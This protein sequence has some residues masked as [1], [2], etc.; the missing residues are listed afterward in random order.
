MAMFGL[1]LESGRCPDG[2]EIV[3]TAE[4]EALYFHS[5]TVRREQVRLEIET[6]E[7]PVVVEFINARTD[8]KLAEFFLNYGPLYWPETHH[9]IS[10]PRGE[11]TI[12]LGSDLKF[13]RGMQRALRGR[14]A[15]AGG[16]SRVNALQ[17]INDMIEERGAKRLSLQPVLDLAGEG[18]DP[19]MLLKC[20]DLIKFMYLEVV[21]TAVQGAKFATC[22]RCSDV[23]LTGP[24]TGRRSHAKYCSGRCRVAAMRARNAENTKQEGFARP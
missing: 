1:F 23:F 14:L 10:E 7:N 13:I 2:V 16:S 12:V 17:A 4:G 24:L 21:M 11:H 9:N 15:N 8:E 20:D 18:G 5:R 6:L 3:A 22:E 19:R